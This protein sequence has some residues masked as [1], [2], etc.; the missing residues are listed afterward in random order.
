MSDPQVARW[1]QSGCV[2]CWRFVD[3]ASNYPGWNVTADR[4]GCNSMLHLF[5]LMASA[6]HPSSQCVRL[7]RPSPGIA[8][9]PGNRGGQARWSSGASELEIKFRKNHVPPSHWSL[10]RQGD[11]LVLIVGQDK[12]EE[13]RRGFEDIMNGEGDWGIGPDDDDLQLVYFWPLPRGV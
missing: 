5:N 9:G 2:Y 11:S 10:E 6:M 3:N 7:T 8:A 1:K 12:L 4:D 13:L